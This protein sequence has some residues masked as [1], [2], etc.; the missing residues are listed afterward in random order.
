[1][2]QII[3]IREPLRLLLARNDFDLLER[4]VYWWMLKELKQKQSL[5]ETD[6]PVDL[7]PF[8]IRVSDLWSESSE[9]GKDA[10]H[11]INYTTYKKITNRLTSRKIFVENWQ[12]RQMGY[13]VV[14]TSA[15]YDDGYMEVKL[16]PILVPYMID[17]SKG[18]TQLQ[19]KSALALTSEYAQVLYTRLCRFLDTGFWRVSVDEFREIMQA[20]TYP[21]Y[22]NLKQ[23]VLDPAVEEISAKADIEVTYTAEKAG[24]SVSFL[25]FSIKRRPEHSAEWYTESSEVE[26]QTDMALQTPLAHRRLRA[27]EVFNQQYNFTYKQMQQVINDETLLNEFVRL[28]ILIQ[29][30]KLDIRTTPTRYIAGILFKKRETPPGQTTVKNPTANHA[31]ASDS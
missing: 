5:K 13:I 2:S 1:M 11:S 16:N 20:D 18:Y 15:F 25:H 19:L 7:P 27:M 28:D 23:R 12:N 21:R 30:G 24:R 14:Y 3:H 10:H 9:N 4:R 6:H 22:S 31:P 8:R 29:H 17:L 26:E